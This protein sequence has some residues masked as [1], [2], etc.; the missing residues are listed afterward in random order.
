MA[1]R[2]G[3]LLIKEKRITPA[4]LEEALDRQ[5]Q[6]GGRLAFNLITLGFV[7]DEEITELLSKQF[8]VPSIS[9]GAFEIDPAVIKL[10][11][12]E[13]ARKYQ[14]VPLSSAGATLTIAITDPTN[15]FAMDDLRFMT[16]Y[17][18]EP[19]VASEIAVMDAIAKYYDQATG[20]GSGADR[21][22][23]PD[24]ESQVPEV[25][26]ALPDVDEV[27]V[28]GELEEISAE[29][30]AK[31]GAE[32]AIIHL[33]N[34]L[35]TS[36][37]EKCASDIH[38]EPYE[39]EM[40]VRYRVDGILYKIMSP[41]MRF[42]DA[43]TS[44]IKIMAKL[45]IS[46]RRLPQDGR[47]K[48]QLQ[49]NDSTKD[50]DFRVSCLPTLF[51][52]KIVLRLLDKDKLMLDMTKLGFERESLVKFEAA[53]RKPWAWCSSPARPDPARPTRCTRRSRGSIRPKRTS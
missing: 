39:K 29:M 27:E 43:V 23:A 49:N 50:I 46:E 8:G 44:R 19:V 6:Y 4:Q 28:L 24:E 20:S 38:I 21:T 52:E 36:A 32:T 5:R 3:D 15:V 53:I 48:I 40:R 34:V 41:P 37:I 10:V 1:V 42:R 12:V 14:V 45:D 33:V 7:K 25:L 16:G 30:L 26:P 22:S 13:T 11:K 47:V 51:G 18:V 9:L 31:Q 35:L 17:N 2:L